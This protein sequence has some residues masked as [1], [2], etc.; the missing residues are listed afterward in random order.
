MAGGHQKHFQVAI[1]ISRPRAPGPVAS[2]IQQAGRRTPPNAASRQGGLTERRQF[3]GQDTTREIWPR[4]SPR[5]S[6]APQCAAGGLRA[7]HLSSVHDEARGA[8]LAI[9][10]SFAR[11]ASLVGSPWQ[12]AHK[13]RGGSTQQTDYFSTTLDGRPRAATGA[14]RTPQ[15]IPKNSDQMPVLFNHTSASSACLKRRLTVAAC[16]PKCSAISAS[17][18]PYC[19]TADRPRG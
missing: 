18:Y 11:P 9:T 8:G 4:P 17:R 7:R 10:H 13:M 2:R 1:G 14:N 6:T 19:R 5:P 15:H 3:P 12:D 16:T